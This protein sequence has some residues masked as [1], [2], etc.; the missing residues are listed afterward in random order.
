MSVAIAFVGLVGVL[1]GCAWLGRGQRRALATAL[2][3]LGLV[4]S[5]LG[6]VHARVPGFFGD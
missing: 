6:V 4:A 5:C 2:V 3:C 1:Q